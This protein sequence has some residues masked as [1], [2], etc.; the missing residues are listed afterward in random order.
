MPSWIDNF[1]ATP[2]VG[3]RLRTPW[4]FVGRY[5]EIL[6]PLLDD[7]DK[8]SVNFQVGSSGTIGNYLVDTDEGFQYVLEPNNLVVQFKYKTTAVQGA[9]KLPELK[10]N[11]VYPYSELVEQSRDRLL[12]L[13]DQFARVGKLDGDRVGVVANCRIPPGKEPPGLAAILG[14][15]A[16]PWGRPFRMFDANLLIPLVESKDR[17]VQCHHRVSLDRTAEDPEIKF[18]IDWQEL[19]SEPL[20]LTKGFSKGLTDRV[21]EAMGYFAKVGEGALHVD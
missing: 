4:R 10:N 8:Q 5:V 19:R 2:A 18:V 14:Q 7:L 17:I 16:V 9:G 15:L 21:H 20:N 12:N 3:V 13:L 1:I 6:G 11:K